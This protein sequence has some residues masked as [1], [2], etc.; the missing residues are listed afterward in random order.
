MVQSLQEQLFHQLTLEQE[1][2]EFGWT[3][4]GAESELL[5]CSHDGIGVHNCNHFEDASVRCEDS[6]K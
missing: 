1:L 3:M 2:V 6:C 5:D 4:S